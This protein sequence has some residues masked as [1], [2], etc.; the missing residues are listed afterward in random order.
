MD[1]LQQQRSQRQIAYWLLT[2][3][4]MIIIQ[5]LL[6]GITRLTE[7]GLSI[8]EWKPITGTLPPMNDVA[9]QAEFDK[10][11]VT[12]QFKYVHQDFTLSEF[13][14][15]FFWEW[16]HRTWARLMGVVFLIGFVY[17]IATKKFEKRMI[18]PMVILFILGGL[19]GYIGWFMVASGLVPEKYFVGHVELATHFIAALGLLCYTLWFAL[20]LLVTEHQKVNDTKLKNLLLFILTVLFLQLIYGA[21]LAGLR[22]AI[23]APTWPDINGSII[24]ADMAEL[25][26]FAKNL[27]ANPIM[28]HFIHR[29]LAYLLLLLIGLWWFKSKPVAN[30]KLFN[31]LRMALVLLV[32]LQAVLG[33]S[34]V[35]NATYPNR[36]VMLGVSH[37]FVAMILLMV[38]VALLFI[39]KK[40]ERYNLQGV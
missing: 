39:V 29:G 3:V 11:K 14:F 15:I 35:L 21:F 32:L 7:S 23:T 18:K 40:K 2:G 31:R 27:V 20:S 36:L 9:W 28:I 34:T 30:N 26:P 24:P 5:V 16:F 37:Q 19:Q 12:D 10:Y 33:I 13:K 38:M 25:S 1:T 8:T 4:I 17:F 6:G 22:A